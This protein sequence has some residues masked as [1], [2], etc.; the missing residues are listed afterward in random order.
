MKN[1]I[2][3][4]I[5]YFLMLQSVLSAQCNNG[6]NI[7]Y[8]NVNATY[9]VGD[10]INP[11]E[12]IL[13]GTTTVAINSITTLG[14]GFNHPNGLAVDS[15]GNIFVADI[16][17]HAIKKI[18]ANGSITTILSN[19]NGLY[20]LALNSIDEVYF[21][22]NYIYVNSYTH[23]NLIKKINSNG[24]ISTIYSTNSEGFSSIAF[25]IFDNLYFTER[26][27]DPQVYRFNSNEEIIYIGSGSEFTEGLAVDVQ[28]NVYYESWSYPLLYAYYTIRRLT[29][30]GVL[31]DYGDLGIQKSF[32]VD[33]FGSLYVQDNCLG[34]DFGSYSS[35]CLENLNY[36]KKIKSNGQIEKLFVNGIG[37]YHISKV[38]ALGNTLY[39]YDNNSVKMIMLNY[40]SITPAL[41]SGLSLNASTGVIS[42]EPQETTPLTTYTI[43]VKNACGIQNIPIS[44][45]TVSVNSIVKLKL[46]IEGY[47][48]LV[49]TMYPIKSM[50]NMTSPYNQ[51]EDLEVELCDV[52]NYNTIASQ[53]AILYTNGTIRCNFDSS[54]TGLYYVKVK[55]LNII[56][57][58]SSVPI[59]VSSTI[60]YYNFS[61]AKTKSFGSNVYELY[62]GVCAFYSGDINQ[63][64]NIDNTDYSLWETDS[65][66][67]VT[68]YFATDLNGDGNVDNTDYSIWEENA[69]NFI[70]VIR[71]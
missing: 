46:Y 44:F 51:V 36:I 12:P 32:A 25:D 41:P 70:S 54:I 38:D 35:D 48:D 24:T 39:V 9:T 30:Q 37:Y 14:S 10:V 43:T 18:D 62:D 16:G 67:F 1:S 66:N 17:N 40:Y 33:S 65:N 53:V 61:N 69:N 64:G 71:P 52:N 2:V 58:W 49:E 15:Y 11:I 56:E 57:T 5:A 26:F 28:G 7:T 13:E 47:Y 20:G 45:E 31:T 23:I 8:P 29:P 63:D 6:L 22:D 50:R 4:S 42:G 34:Y 68:G 59:N 3:L 27:E 60:A 21:I 55:G 19:I